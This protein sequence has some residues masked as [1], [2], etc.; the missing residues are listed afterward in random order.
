MI[1]LSRRFL[2]GSL[3]LASVLGLASTTA[4][5]QNTSL[6]YWSFND[7]TG[8]DANA[9]F[10]ANLFSADGGVNR[11]SATMSSNFDNIDGATSGTVGITSFTG[12]TE[13]ATLPSGTALTAGQDLGL[14]AFTNNSNNGKFLQ[15]GVPTTGYQNVVLTY[16]TRGSSSGFNPVQLSYSI[17]GTV[18]TDFGAAYA[19]NVTTYSTKTYDLTAIVAANNV[20]NLQFRLTFNGATTAA[21]NNRL[22]NVQINAAPVGSAVVPEAGSLALFAVPMLALGAIAIRRKK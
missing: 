12:T 10:R 21:G 8:T 15:F 22:D 19:G 16:A 13:N 1:F 9:A 7:A 11:T 4:F 20:P 14:Q 18:F 17:N 3:A 2:T 6:A 5:A